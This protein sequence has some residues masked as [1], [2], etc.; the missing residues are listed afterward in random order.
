MAQPHR[1]RDA[2]RC[3]RIPEALMPLVLDTP[4]ATR[5]D[6]M[7]DVIAVVLH[8]LSFSRD[9]LNLISDQVSMLLTHNGLISIEEAPNSEPFASLTDWLMSKQP[10]AAAED[11]DDLLH[12]MVDDILD[13]IFPMLEQMANQLDD[14]PA[15]QVLV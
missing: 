11:L 4:Q 12:Y 14:L 3:C 8:R 2:L 6:S 10:A 1:I 9:P 7:G 5:V 13:D 15:S